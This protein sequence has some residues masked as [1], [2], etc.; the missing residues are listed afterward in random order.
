M[1]ARS[2][3]Y[4]HTQRVTA[5]QRE[6]AQHAPR[7]S[8]VRFTVRTSG[9]GETRLLGGAALTFGALLIEEP[10]FSWGAIAGEP[11]R[12]GQLPLCTAIVLNYLVTPGG[13]YYGAQMGFKVESAKF[14]IRMKYSLTFEATTLRST[15]GN[16]TDQLVVRG[17]N[18]Y[19]GGGSVGG[20][21]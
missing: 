19:Q 15:A 8:R 21:I 3:I 11:L 7:P 14:D 13:Q 2:E 17:Q 4:E 12:A 5:R 18:A 6:L 1:D 9:T 20:Q 10:S 16:G